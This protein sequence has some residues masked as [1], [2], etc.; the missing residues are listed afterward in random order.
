M[1]G[2]MVHTLKVETRCFYDRIYL[3]NPIVI[4]SF[5]PIKLTRVEGKQKLMYKPIEINIDY[6]L[7]KIE[8]SG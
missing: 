1:T 4:R 8:E 2:V 5:T 3:F 6:E 7:Y